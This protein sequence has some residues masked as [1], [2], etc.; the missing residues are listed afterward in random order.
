MTPKR[1][2]EEWFA[3]ER[4]ATKIFDAECRAKGALMPFGFGFLSEASREPYREQARREANPAPERTGSPSQ[5]QTTTEQT[6]PSQ[7]GEKP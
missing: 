2:S 4:A 1:Y 3:L 6:S 5:A 7:Q